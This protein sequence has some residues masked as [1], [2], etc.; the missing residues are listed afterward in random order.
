MD[1]LELWA[2][3]RLMTTGLGPDAEWFP[4]LPGPHQDLHDSF[5]VMVEQLLP[6]NEDEEPYWMTQAAATQLFNN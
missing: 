3:G 6:E 4:Q 1:E 2:R 5:W